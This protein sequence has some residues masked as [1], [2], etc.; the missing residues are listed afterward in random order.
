MMMRAIYTW[1]L[2]AG[3]MNSNSISNCYYLENNIEIIGNGGTLSKIG[4]EKTEEYMKGE[5]FVDKLNNGQEGNPWK[6]DINNINDGYP[7]LSWQ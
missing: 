3:D 6:Q 2:F 5:E 4:E 1:G 7:I